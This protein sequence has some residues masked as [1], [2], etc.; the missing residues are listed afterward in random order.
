MSSAAIQARMRLYCPLQRGVRRRVTEGTESAG[1]RRQYLT[2]KVF[3]SIDPNDVIAPVA[4][5]GEAGR[6]TK[7]ELHRRQAAAD[8]IAVGEEPRLDLVVLKWAVAKNGSSGLGDGED[9]HDTL[10]Q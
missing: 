8:G 4:Q 6:A 3:L 5:I 1:S 9:V 2:E 10:L 7:R